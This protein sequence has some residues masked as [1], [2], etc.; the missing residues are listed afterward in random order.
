MKPQRLHPL[1]PLLKGVRAFWVVIAALSWQG[2]A[3]FGVQRGAVIVALGGLGALLYSF[4]V[5]RVSSFAVV[6]RELR[7]Q[8]GLVV[9]R[10]RAVPLERMQS[11]EVI[12]PLLAQLTGLAELRIEVVGGDKSEAR[13]A[14]L[15][16]A[17]A[18]RLRVELLA[19][20]QSATA[21][22]P[23]PEPVA[24]GS[25]EEV[26]HRVPLRDLAIS[27]ALTWSTILS[28][29]AL[30]VPVALF[31]YRPELSFV[32]IAGTVTAAL[33]T[34]GTPVRR[35]LRFYGFTVAR[36]PE[37]LRISHGATETRHQTVP[38]ERVQSVALVRPLLW[39]SEGWVACELHVA[40]V[41]TGEGEAVADDT[42]L[43]VADPATAWPIL[44]RALPGAAGAATMPL[45]PAPDVARWR[46]PVRARTLGF[47]LTP[48]LF[49]TRS[50]LFSPRVTVVPFS[51]IQAVSLEQG[52]WQRWLG[53]ASVR[54]HTAGGARVAADYR[55]VA[56]AN[57]LAAEL[58][59]RAAA[60][61]H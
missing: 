56:E 9:R 46:A 55:T 27:Q 31:A 30:A 33:G 26:L 3:R 5:W 23:L 34:L 59:A 1:T 50:G 19:L 54:V 32:G 48:D 39:R 40:G 57:W 25:G 28:P 13:L 61:R 4:V 51:R 21:T 36:V 60:A 38:M 10:N 15:P 22:D 17:D 20:K 42:L 49:V 43:P 52:P 7:I 47:G 45:A 6:D 29:F 37:G 12:R 8:E 24:A 35:F 14:Y 44:D 16:V 58:H 53:L 2:F 18:E 11:I 41:R